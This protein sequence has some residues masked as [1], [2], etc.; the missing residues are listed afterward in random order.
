MF[1]LADGDMMPDERER[2]IEHISSCEEC[3]REMSSVLS[4]NEKL[5]RFWSEYLSSKC[6]DEETLFSFLEEKLTGDQLI[7]VELHLSVCPICRYKVESARESLEEIERLEKAREELVSSL[8]KRLKKKLGK[9]D[10]EKALEGLEKILVP[11]RLGEELF[12][13]LS[14]SVEVLTYPF[15]TPLEAPALM[16]VAAGGVKLAD[17]GRG[18][19]RKIVAEE[20]TPFEIELVQF[21]ER[22][23]LNLKTADEAYRECLVR[24]SLLEGTEVRRQK[25]V[26]V[27]EGKA[28]VRFSEEEIEALRPEKSPLKLNLKVLLKGDVISNL[29]AED[30][31]T[32]LERL[33]ALLLSEDPEIAEATLETLKK[34]ETLIPD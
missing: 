1:S 31:V 27:S 23:T 30:V 22:F 2:I 6:P 21:G 19:Q 13:F 3:K 18:F 24:Y 9:I 17:T 7:E 26:L 10:I 12:A 5:R 25:V 20:G 11:S 15:K 16:P 4:F 29:K 28:A 32:F 14:R 8:I 33:Q 34:I